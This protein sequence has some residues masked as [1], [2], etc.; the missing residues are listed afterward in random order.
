MSSQT[1]PGA[2]SRKPWRIVVGTG[3][4]VAAAIHD[5]HEVRDEVAALLAID[6]ATRLREQ[7]PFTR[8]WA[9]IAPTHFVVHRSRFELD[10]NR[11]RERAVY[12]TPAD[13]WGLDVWRSTPSAD[14]IDR[15]LALYDEFYAEAQRVLET[16]RAAHGAFVVL[17]LHTYN[18]RREGPNGPPAEASANPEVNIGTGSMDRDRWGSLVDRFMDKLSQV[19]VQGRRLDVR[20]NV[21][22]QGGRF[23]RWI[24]ETFPAE[25]CSL[26]IEFKKFF[27]DEWTGEGH[28]VTIQEITSA[29]RATLAGVSEEL[30]RRQT[31]PKT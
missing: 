23:S 31:P 17:D 15:S 22:F 5:G 10:L 13:A 3:P 18:H 27:M 25:G 6:D 2:G 21:K 16:V 9:A 19:E 30:S 20:E 29:L 24:H 28:E 4:L 12:V 11:P 1:W 26:A 14:L 7:D 8:E